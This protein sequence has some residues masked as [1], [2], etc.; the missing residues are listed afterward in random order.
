MGPQSWAAVQRSP[1]L[2]VTPELVS[3]PLHPRA[4]SASGAP[5]LLGA[6]RTA[7]RRQVPGAG[8]P[9]AAQSVPLPFL[10][11]QEGGDFAWP[12]VGSVCGVCQPCLL[13]SLSRAPARADTGHSPR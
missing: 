5:C 10:A 4:A 12:P 13:H 11:R 2:A 7:M 1:L 3:A 8:D 9:V 6:P